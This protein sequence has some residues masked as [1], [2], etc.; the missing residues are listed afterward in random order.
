MIKKCLLWFFSFVLLWFWFSFADDSVSLPYSFYVDWVQNTVS[1][2]LNFTNSNID[3]SQWLDLKWWSNHYYLF[4]NNWRLYSY[5]YYSWWSSYNQW[6]FSKACKWKSIDWT[7][8]S[9]C[10]YE[11]D[12][13]TWNLDEFYGLQY[14]SFT[15]LYISYSQSTDQP[16]ICFYNSLDEYYYC[17]QPSYS[18]LTWSLEIP[19]NTLNF[20]TYAWYSP[21]SISSSFTNT[22][23]CPTV[24]QVI[25]NYNSNWFYSWMCY[26]SDK[27][28]NWSTFETI[29]PQSILDLYS[30]SESF[31]NDLYKFW[32]YCESSVY[33]QSVCQE[34]FSWQVYKFN[35]LSKLPRNLTNLWGRKMTYVYCN[36]YT[37][38]PNAT[39]CTL[40]TWTLWSL[41]TEFTNS[42]VVHSLANWNYSIVLPN[43][44]WTVYDADYTWS[45]DIISNVQNLFTRFTSLFKKQTWN[46]NW[47]LPTWII[48]PFL[49]LVL[50]KLFKK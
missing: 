38:D 39:T 4:W 12:Y 49:I 23:Q 42:D 3:W 2:D 6:Y 22:Y 36:L 5:W 47:F 18:Q 9:L 15:R 30:S 33:N 7:F 14:Y 13:S 34:A 31:V 11:N 20:R 10:V 8:N 21:F 35:L 26:T 16:K 45:G 29:E 32:Q 41:W 40:W 50:F 44:S 19:D 37:L 46:S 24:K 48:Y 25:N 17:F 43:T 27:I 28:F 1:K